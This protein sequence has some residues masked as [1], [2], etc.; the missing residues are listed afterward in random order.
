M[1]PFS[2]RDGLCLVDEHDSVWMVVEFLYHQHAS[3]QIRICLNKQLFFAIS[4]SNLTA[5]LY[6]PMLRGTTAMLSAGHR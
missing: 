1:V 5:A 2:T 3:G 4:V 6:P